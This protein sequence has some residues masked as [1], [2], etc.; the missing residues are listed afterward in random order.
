MI[1]DERLLE[2]LTMH[3]GDIADV[4]LRD[5]D[6]YIAEA[7][8]H[9]FVQMQIEAG[10]YKP[11][12][13]AEDFVSFARA[14]PTSAY[15]AGRPR[16][17]FCPDLYR[18]VLDGIPDDI[19]EDYL[20]IMARHERAHIEAARSP[21]TA[22]EHLQCEA[23]AHTHDPED[24]GVVEYVERHSRPFGRLTRRVAAI[25][26]ARLLGELPATTSQEET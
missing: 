9:V 24:L 19:A 15:G 23:E 1:S 5:R 11:G 12:T 7:R 10:M 26:V 16:V 17:V 6:S 21:L 14:E 3:I 22:L 18:Q 13:L 4:V 25:R 20:G 8:R 2:L